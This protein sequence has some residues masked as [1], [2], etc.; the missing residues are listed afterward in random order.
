M[1]KPAA[2][3]VEHSSSSRSCKGLVGAAD[4]SGQTALD[5]KSFTGAVVAAVGVDDPPFDEHVLRLRSD[6][7]VTMF[8]LP[9][10]QMAK[11]APSSTAAPTPKTAA[12]PKGNPKKKAKAA[13]KADRNKPEALSGMETVTKEGSNICW[14]YNLEAGCQA[15]LVSGSKPPRCAKGL[16]VCA[17]CHKPNHSQLVCSLK[18]RGN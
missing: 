9:L 4:Q 10:P 13:K 17:F 1:D 8:L 5:A 12:A 6:P 2:H 7:R 15:A 14:S 18:K 3:D 16:H 11:S